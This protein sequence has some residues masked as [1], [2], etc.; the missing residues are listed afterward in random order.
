MSQWHGASHLRPRILVL[1][2]LRVEVAATAEVVVDLVEV[3]VVG[4]LV[5]VAVTSQ[6]QAPKGHWG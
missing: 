5:E 4:D 2:R 1:Q 3:A 6:R